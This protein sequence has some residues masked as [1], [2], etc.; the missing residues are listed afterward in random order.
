MNFLY[1]FRYFYF[2][3]TN[4]NLKLAFFTLYYEIKGER[5]Y[6]INTI[7]IDRLHNL[8]INSPNLVHASIYQ[9]VNYF[10]LEKAFDF[11]KSENA[12]KNI[13]DFGCG[14]GRVMIVAAHYNFTNITGIDFSSQLCLE[15]EKNIAPIKGLYPSTSFEII[16]H[17]AVNY[18]IEKQTNVFFFFN[19]FDQVVMLKVV[20]N[21][22]ISL[23]ESA[24]KIYIVYV[25]PLHKEIFLSAGFEEEYYL[26]KMEYIELSIL[27]KEPEEE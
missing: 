12:N 24:R 9:G 3:A 5:K 19:P 14:K 13:V 2:I 21:I 18:K 27:S 22:L 15:T 1:Y 20:K 4:W 25:N 26:R 8:E 17:D 11:L 6:Q 7:K 16:C 23:K 10:A